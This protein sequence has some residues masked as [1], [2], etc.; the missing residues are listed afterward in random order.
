MKMALFGASLAVVFA[1]LAGWRSR[2]H[3]A[4]RTEMVRLLALQPQAPRRFDPAMVADLPEPAQRYFR[5]AIAEGTPLLTVA[6]LSMTGLFSLGDK[7]RP[8]YLEM[9]ARQVLASPHGFVWKMRTQSGLL[10]MS[11]S[12]SAAWTR[13]WMGGI[14][15][16]ARA[17]GDKDHARAAF[18][19]MVAEAV[20]WTPAAVLPGRGVT[21]QPVGP[22]VAKVTVRHGAMTQ[23]V[24]VTVD[25]DGQPLS[26]T[27]PRW[28]NANPEKQYQEQPFGG[29]LSKFQSFQG[30]RVPTHVEAGNF[31]GTDRYFPFFIADVTDIFYP[32]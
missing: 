10:P 15:P 12:D 11:G 20:F 8:D 7:D 1:I 13:F 30:Y 3:D 5:F 26:V 9:R 19:R 14:V 21:W 17:G 27:F 32:E 31:F 2:D 22:D 28:S 16:V 25:A 6:D 23:S 29:F 24:D 18:G 4:D